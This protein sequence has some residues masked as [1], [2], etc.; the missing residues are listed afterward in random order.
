MSNAGLIVAEDHLMALDSTG[1][2]FTLR[3]FRR[4]RSKPYQTNSFAG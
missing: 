4:L 1:A 2:R 3:V